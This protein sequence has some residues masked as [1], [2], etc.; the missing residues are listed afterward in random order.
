MF[1]YGYL[2]SFA[3]QICL[4]NN[5]RIACLSL[6]LAHG[7]YPGEL[8]TNSFVAA[9]IKRGVELLRKTVLIFVKCKW[10]SIRRRGVASESMGG[11]YYARM[12]VRMFSPFLAVADP[13]MRLAHVR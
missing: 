2:G 5:I 3:E 9:I 1:V 7:I 8:L 12:D 4:G 10:P 11:I 13:E 6:N